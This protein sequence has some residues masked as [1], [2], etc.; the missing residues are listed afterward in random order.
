MKMC[1]LPISV[2]GEVCLGAILIANG[3]VKVL[4]DMADLPDDDF[5]QCYTSLRSLNLL[6]Y[7]IYEIRQYQSQYPQTSGKAINH[8]PS[9]GIRFAILEQI[10][11]S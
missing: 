7:L 1:E 9:P 10:D 6:R 11:P 4:G 8:T 3:K 2:S 5:C